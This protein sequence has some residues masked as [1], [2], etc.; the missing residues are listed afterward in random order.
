MRTG[1][2]LYRVK[3][4]HPSKRDFAAEPITSIHIISAA[5]I[6]QLTMNAPVRYGFYLG[7]FKFHLA[8]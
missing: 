7:Y 5:G 4:S 6:V 3:L 1:R 2:V 8:P